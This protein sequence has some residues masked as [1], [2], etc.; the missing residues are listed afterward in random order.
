M[1][2]KIDKAAGVKDQ[3]DQTITD[4]KKVVDGAENEKSAVETVKEDLI[5]IEITF[6]ERLHTFGRVWE[7]GKKY[8]V[9]SSMAK[10]LLKL[11]DEGKPYFARFRDKAKAVVQEVEDA[12]TVRKPVPVVDTRP[13]I[14]PTAD[15]KLEVGTPEE[16]AALF[17]NVDKDD[18]APAAPA[19]DVV[20]L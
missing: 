2:V 3:I 13:Q 1:A 15:G 8:L 18:D 6:L 5:A 19:D 20:K 12:I 7:K 10:E 9:E 17:A 16:E 4:A 11:E 14:T